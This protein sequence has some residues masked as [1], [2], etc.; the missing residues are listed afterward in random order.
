MTKPT[1]WL[2][3]QRR[4]RSAWASVWVFGGCTATLLV[5]SLGGSYTNPLQQPRLEVSYNLS[6][7]MTKPTKWPVYPAKT[8]ISLGIRPVWSESSLTAWR[9][10]GPLTT[11]KAHSEGSNL[12]GQ[13]LRLIWVLAGHISQL[14]GF[15]ML[16]L[17][18]GWPRKIS[19]KLTLCV[20]SPYFKSAVY[21]WIW[22]ESH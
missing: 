3:A 18:Y 22:T 12:T 9:N 2:C 5:L 15:V 13:M 10:L 7:C 21:I 6:H 20:I 14:V 19:Q 8:W 1:M 16:L 17:N 11:N 4:L